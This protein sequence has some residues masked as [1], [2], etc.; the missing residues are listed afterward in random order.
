MAHENAGSELSKEQKRAL[1]RAVLEGKAPA[2]QLLI[3]MW[4]DSEGS[5][6]EWLNARMT[7]IVALDV[8]K[9]AMLR[10]SGYTIDRSSK[11]FQ[12]CSEIFTGSMKFAEEQVPQIKKHMSATVEH[13]GE[14]IAEIIDSCVSRIMME[15]NVMNREAWLDVLT[16]HAK[17]CR[18]LMG[19]TQLPEGTDDESHT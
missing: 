10:E 14:R 12:T 18:A 13:S 8:P 17:L 6:K 2:L 15:D 16:T 11:E 5:V 7:E 19:I 1:H 9:M 3:E 4:K